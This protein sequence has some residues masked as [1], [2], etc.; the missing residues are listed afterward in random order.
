MLFADYQRTDSSIKASRESDFAFLDRSAMP[1]IERVRQFLEALVK[2]YPEEE[3]AELV[4]RIQSGN[5]THFK[6]S[7][8]ELALHAFLVRLGYSLR[9]HPQLPNGS[10]ARPDFHVMS[11]CGEDFYLEAVLASVDDD[12]DPGAEARIGLTLDAL[13]FASHA[14]FMVAVE[15]EGVPHTQ[16]SGKKLLAATLKWLDS[17]DPDEIRTEIECN[18][19]D[20]VPPLN[21]EH[22]EWQVVLRAIPLKPERRGCARTLI[23]VLDGGVGPIDQWSPIRNAIKFKGSK[24]GILDKPLLIAVNFGSF[25]LDRMDEMQALFGQ[26]QYLIAVQNPEAEPRFDRAPNGAWLGKS[27]PQARRVSGAWIFND[28]TAYTLA[29]RRHT[30]YFNPWAANSLP[31]ALKLMPHAL[32]KGEE[33]QWYPGSSLSEVLELPLDWPENL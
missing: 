17:L 15:Y 32:V 3:H 28:L 7:I 9:P 2:D 19:L 11:P 27:G 29:S 23:G 26:E 1:E 8:F 18:G 5:D 16:P 13:S 33:M 31:E 20:S 22:E 24:Y 12:S 30:I 10:K 21:W 6:S 14:N 25:H 4:A